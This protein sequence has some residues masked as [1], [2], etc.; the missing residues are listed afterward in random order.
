MSKG[1]FVPR[2]G[3][4]SSIVGTYGTGELAGGVELGGPM[5]H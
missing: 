1:H 2:G 3:T 4:M 5:A